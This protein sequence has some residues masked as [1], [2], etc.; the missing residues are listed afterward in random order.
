MQPATEGISIVSSCRIAL[1]QVICAAFESG[2]GGEGGRL[3][4]LVHAAWGVYVT[5]GGEEDA[6]DSLA[7]IVQLAVKPFQL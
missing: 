2:L 1:R 5:G 4:E 3:Q 7:R 6:L